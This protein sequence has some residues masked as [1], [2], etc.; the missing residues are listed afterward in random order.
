MT[1]YT[2]VLQGALAWALAHPDVTT[3]L[4]ALVTGSAHTAR[5]YRRTGRLPLSALPW[6]AFRRLAF[7]IR[8][9]WFTY[10]K[11]SESALGTI[12]ARFPGF[13]VALARQSYEPAWPFSF[14]YKGEDLNARR[15]VLD[16]SREYPHR[17]VH[18]R[19]WDEGDHVEIE[20]HEEPSALHHPRKHLQ[21]TDMHDATDWVA[22]RYSNGNGLD[23]R[24]FEP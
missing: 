16:E 19:A 8:R 6:R 4:L 2:T 13:T 5:T 21:S 9:R 11:P 12:D 23:P 17:Q 24:G 1:D 10:P 22:E 3:A 15:Y 14:Y 7:A 20:A 18:I